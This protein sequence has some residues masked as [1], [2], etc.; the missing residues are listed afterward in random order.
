MA[1]S[2]VLMGGLAWAGGSGG[3]QPMWPKGFSLVPQDAL[4]VLSLEKGGKLLEKAGPGAELFLA[5]LARWMGADKK[6]IARAFLEGPFTAALF[7]PKEGVPSLLLVFPGGRKGPE[8]LLSRLGKGPGAYR[9]AGRLGGAEVGSYTLAPPVG[10]RLFTLHRGDTFLAATSKDLLARALDAEASPATK[11]LQADIALARI[12]R[13][14]GFKDGGGIFLSFKKGLFRGGPAVFFSPGE[15]KSWVSWMSRLTGKGVETRVRLEWPEPRSGWGALAG[16]KSWPA[17]LEKAFPGPEDLVVAAGLIL[18]PAPKGKA[19]GNSPLLPGLERVLP[20]PWRRIMPALSGD[21]V[22]RVKAKKEGPLAWA[23]LL[24]LTNPSRAD[25]VLRAPGKAWRRKGESTTAGYTVHTLE[26]SSGRRFSWALAGGRLYL[27]TGP[28]LLARALAQAPG[29]SGGEE[30][31]SVSPGGGPFLRAR[32]DT[33]ALALLLPP[34]FRSFLEGCEGP[35]ELEGWSDPAGV[36][37]RFFH[38]GCPPGLPF[39]KSLRLPRVPSRK[40]LAAKE[41]KPTSGTDWGSLSPKERFEAL[42]SLERAGDILVYA[43]EV[44]SLLDDPDPA[45]AARAAYALG[46]NKVESAVP[47]LCKVLRDSPNP[48]VRRYAAYAL[49]RMPD[50]R[51]E[52]FLLQ[53][54]EDEDPWTRGYAATALEKLGSAKAAKPL[55]RALLADPKAPKEVRLRILSALAELGG[56]REIPKVLLGVGPKEDVDLLRAQVYALQKLTPQLSRPEEED[57]LAQLLDSPSAYVKGYA[58]DRL[59]EI[60]GSVAARALERR[61]PLEGPRFAKRI[62]AALDVVKTRSGP[63][64]AFKKVVDATSRKMSLVREKLGKV[65]AEVRTWPAWKKGALACVPLVLAGLLFMLWRWLR[66]RAAM[67]AHMRLI[68]LVSSPEE[69]EGF[70]MEAPGPEFGDSPDSDLP[71]EETPAGEESVEPEADQVYLE[72]QEEVEEMVP[73]EEEKNLEGPA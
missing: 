7:S 16:G 23:A 13:D 17:S 2:L 30:Q 45:V 32:G 72:D 67:K 64:L 25:K 33:A 31:P 29:D 11:S 68:T 4:A 8:Q 15:E 21:F 44:E 19:K 34:F 70:E 53:A 5:R 6:E 58:V 26:D 43:E 49:S 40:G 60:G 1:A 50:P 27:G 65:V 41:E 24:D 69:E 57:L 56:P 10:L 42:T 59:G 55:A 36:G 22:L 73:L 61:L 35:F 52:G 38:D 51:E 66:A 48:E 62:Q 28:D 47:R 20:L 54:L 14:C 46:E 71:W 12:F 63:Q 3:T 39:L 37:F 18:P 9:P